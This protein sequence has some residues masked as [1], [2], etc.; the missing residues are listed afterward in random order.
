MTIIDDI[1]RLFGSAKRD[2]SRAIGV[3][4]S[5]VFHGLTSTQTNAYQFFDGLNGKS[6]TDTIEFT[7]YEKD[8]NGRPTGRSARRRITVADMVNLSGD[9]QEATNRLTTIYS[10]LVRDG[11]VTESP[12]S[13]SDKAVMLRGQAVPVTQQTRDPHMADPRG[14]LRAPWLSQRGQIPDPYNSDDPRGVPSWWPN[15]NDHAP[16]VGLTPKVL[17]RRLTSTE[18]LR[19]T[20]QQLI[21]ACH[22]YLQSRNAPMIFHP[23]AIAAQAHIYPS[24][25]AYSNLNEE[26]GSRSIA[27]WAEANN[28]PRYLLQNTVLGFKFPEG[29]QH[30]G[31]VF[32]AHNS[33]W[34]WNESLDRRFPITVGTGTIQ[35]RGAFDTGE[36]ITSWPIYTAD[37]LLE[38]QRWVNVAKVLL[39]TGNVSA[40]PKACMVDAFAINAVYTG[41]QKRA[42]TQ[43]N[44][45][46]HS[47]VVGARERFAREALARKAA[48]RGSLGVP[49]Y[50]SEGDDAADISMGLVGSVALAVSDALATGGF[51]VGVAVG[52]VSFLVRGGSLLATFLGGP[53]APRNPFDYPIR[54]T[55]SD[56]SPIINGLSVNNCLQLPPLYRV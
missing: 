6:P 5:H 33:Q 52:I 43:V 13:D 49:G 31:P 34:V 15:I 51:P 26:S 53:D 24:R 20:Y 56:S 23:L 46:M 54:M 27:A 28:D 42:Y 44:L 41:A 38:L 12:L 1:L 50:H 9:Y 47:N 3:G 16:V 7:L 25:H 55:A 39:S 48:Q 11:L 29:F 10:R 22:R 30:S 8:S 19:D 18:S 21:F 37:A 2:V 40:D 45:P 14:I 32:G 17:D 36:R 35:S 4:N